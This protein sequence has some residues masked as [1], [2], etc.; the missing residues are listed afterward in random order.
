MLQTNRFHLQ[1]LRTAL[2][3][4]L[5]ILIHIRAEFFCCLV[6]VMAVATSTYRITAVG[7]TIRTAIAH[8]SA[9]QIIQ[10]VDSSTF[11]M[12][13]SACLLAYSIFVD[14]EDRSQQHAQDKRHI[15]QMRV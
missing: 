8:V 2:L 7:R 10:P 12:L 13:P 5:L 1:P 6:A 3:N 11:A 15:T 4:A 14:C 9:N